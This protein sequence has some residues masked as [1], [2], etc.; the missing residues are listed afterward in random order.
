MKPKAP[1]LT[2]IVHDLVAEMDGSFSAEHGVG[3]L[4]VGALE[5]YGDPAKLG[6]MRAI[7]DALDPKG[8]M[9]PGGCVIG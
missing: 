8:I 1:A 9:N 2:E 5:R 7:K 6:A 3:R 4:K